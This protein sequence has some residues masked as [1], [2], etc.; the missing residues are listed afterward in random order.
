MA[1]TGRVSVSKVT[2][3]GYNQYDVTVKFD[4]AFDWG[5][6]NYNGAYYDIWCNGSYQTGTTT[7]AID[8]GGG[9][10]VWGNIGSKTFRV[11]MPKSGATN[12]VTIS[13]YIQTGCEPPTITVSGKYTLPARTWQWP[14]SYN[15]NGG[16]GAPGSQTKTYGSNLTLSTTKPVRTGYIF[17]GWSTEKD[18]AVVYQPGQVY[19]TNAS[20]ALYAVWEIITYKITYNANEG[21]NAPK[22]QIKNHGT[23]LVLSSDKPTRV[24]YNFV[25]WGMSPDSTT[26]LYQ[27][28][29][30]Y[31]K[32]ENITLYAIWILAYVPPRITNLSVDRCYS[33]GTLADDG[34]YARVVFNW[35]TDKTANDIIITYTNKDVTIS[36]SGNKGSVDRVIGDGL[37]NTENYYDI[38]IK[39]TDTHGNTSVSRTVEPMHFTIDI[40]KGGDGIAFGKPASRPGFD[41]NMD[42]FF[43]KK[44]IFDND[45]EINTGKIIIHN[46]NILSNTDLNTIKSPGNYACNDSAVPT[47]LNC[48]T[49]SPFRLEVGYSYGGT[50]HI[51]HKLTE[52]TS[53]R[54]YYRQCNVGTNGWTEWKK[55]ITEDMLGDYIVETGSNSKG[56]Y[57]KWSSGMLEQWGIVVYAATTA[58]VQ[59][60]TV[61]FPINF[62]DTAYNMFLTLTRNGNVA[63][64]I[65][66]SNGGGNVERQVWGCVTRIDKSSSN[67]SVSANWYVIGR[68]KPL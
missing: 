13:G 50:V 25:G 68:W 33:N 5:G 66:E 34:R 65:S 35:E 42:S 26:A 10:W 32:E 1:G 59:T 58:L 7:F 53:G 37:L 15:A 29:D 3:I 22:I 16:S 17:R 43:N 20:L 56:I 38:S 6:W 36:V 54:M 2:P 11:T 61:K 14:V 19:K 8:S 39:I 63:T 52:G 9:S 23:S 47:L 4:I 44:T 24:N 40:K 67:Y 57:R 30:T 49:V 48:P 55:Y 12:A 41:V 21:S 46:A 18:G 27:P 64:K 31:S 28:G 60:N 62:I 45:V 51:Y